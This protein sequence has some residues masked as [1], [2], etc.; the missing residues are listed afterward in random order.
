[1]KI[2]FI[3]AEGNLKKKG[4][5]FWLVLDKKSFNKDDLKINNYSKI[6]VFKDEKERQEFLKGNV[7]SKKRLSQDFF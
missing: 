7:F 2:K 1:M 5:S 4:N 6:F 3:E